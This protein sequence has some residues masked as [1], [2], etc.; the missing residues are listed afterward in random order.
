MM[1]SEDKGSLLPASTSLESNKYNQIVAKLRTNERFAR[2][3]RLF[4]CAE[5]P[6]VE[7]RA[8]CHCSGAASWRS[9]AT[10]VDAGAAAVAVVAPAAATCKRL[11][12]TGREA[13]L[14]GIKWILRPGCR[15][16]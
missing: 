4:Y 15:V 3:G 16:D 10:H 9:A 1:G 14:G 11:G 12:G 5:M 6:R 13:A 2:F 7:Q 8:A